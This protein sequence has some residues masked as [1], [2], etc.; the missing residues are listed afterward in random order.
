VGEY[1]GPIVLDKP[2]V[3]Q[4]EGAMIWARTG[5]VVQVRSAGV[6]ICDLRIEVTQEQPDGPAEA[7]CAL[8][9]A[10][11]CDVRFSDVRIRGS[12][13]GVEGE[14]GDWEY[15]DSLRVGMPSEGRLARWVIR[16]RV[17]VPCR[18]TSSVPNL[19][20]SPLDLVPGV[21]EVY[22]NVG[23]GPDERLLTGAVRV[24]TPRLVRVISVTVD[25]EEPTGVVDA[26]SSGRFLWGSH[27]A[28][29]SEADMPPGNARHLISSSLFR[30]PPLALGLAV[31]LILAAGVQS[32]GLRS[33]VRY[34]EERARWDR[35]RAVEEA[36]RRERAHQF[37]EQEEALKSGQQAVSRTSAEKE[38]AEGELSRLN[39]QLAAIDEKIKLDRQAQSELDRQRDEA[40]VQLREAVQ[41][42]QLIEAGITDLVAR[43]DSLQA[44]AGT[45]EARR[46]QAKKELEVAE[47][48][49][50]RDKPRVE[51]AAAQLTELEAN[52]AS[53]QVNLNKARQAIVQ[54]SKEMEG[55]LGEK[56]KAIKDRDAAQAD[57]AAAQKSAVL[58]RAEL[59]ASKKDTESI[60][61]TLQELSQQTKAARESKEL[62]QAESS[63]SKEELAGLRREVT[64]REEELKG[65][66]DR[67]K[68]EEE[69]RLAISAEA[70]AA[71]SALEPLKVELAKIRAELAA[72]RGATQVR[73][74]DVGYPSGKPPTPRTPSGATPTTPNQPPEIG[75]S[76]PPAAAP[77]RLR[78]GIPN[79]GA[80][81]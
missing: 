28:L 78:A 17:P 59:E 22:L 6:S 63:R 61:A 75:P 70:E 7:R 47:A 11:G 67:V 54:A 55:V 15:P 14:D 36:V 4:G 31:L 65:L 18:L 46:D 51:V 57:Q 21:N 73:D 35:E 34:G 20:L 9:V 30:V 10:Q 53:A 48:T 13:I 2:I 33:L 42:K 60:R 32:W 74:G 56:T 19:H 41:G 16:I 8:R 79:P 81:P 71:R 37:R 58:A 38:K 44:E 1:E 50:R 43:R 76:N 5:P 68:K 29:R 3:L 12:I 23:S 64:S 27:L 66:R 24:F 77:S 72:R 25:A 40:S 62:A 45:L 80:Q 26:R 69:R 39:A 49:L 52:Q